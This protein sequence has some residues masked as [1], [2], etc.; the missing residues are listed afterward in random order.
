MLVKKIGAEPEP[1][2]YSEAVAPQDKVV[3]MHGGFDA[4]TLFHRINI[5]SVNLKFYTANMVDDPVSG[6]AI[7]LAPC[8]EDDVLASGLGGYKNLF[9][10][11]YNAHETMA[12]SFEVTPEAE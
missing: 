9:L 10:M 3:V 4:N 6:N 5:G 8:E 1:V 2:V 11:V 7:G 12:G